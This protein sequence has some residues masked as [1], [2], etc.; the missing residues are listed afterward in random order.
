[1]EASVA[2][3]KE[4]LQE[5]ENHIRESWVKAMEARLVREELGKCHKAEGVNH[6]ENCKWLSEKYLTLLRTNRV[7]GYKV[8][9][10]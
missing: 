4:K 1:M 9:D 7:K 2:A 5:R 8:I 10:T 6:Y 3:I